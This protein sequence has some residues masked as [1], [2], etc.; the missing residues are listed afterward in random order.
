MELV[1]PQPLKALRLCS[2]AALQSRYGF[3]EFAD[4]RKV[5][6]PTVLRPKDGCPWKSRAEFYQAA[7][8]PAISQNPPA[9]SRP[10]SAPEPNVTIA[11][12]APMPVP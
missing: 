4:S 10:Y 6:L 5:K 9:P 3:V 1:L 12:A 11:A 8:S 7:Q 2:A